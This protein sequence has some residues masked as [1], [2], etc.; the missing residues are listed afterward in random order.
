MLSVLND[1][2]VVENV[3]LVKMLV[4]FVSN[5]VVACFLT[6][7][8]AVK[9]GIAPNITLFAMYNHNSEN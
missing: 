6:K 7:C 2:L 4:F 1:A 9:L 5:F 8:Y 3:V